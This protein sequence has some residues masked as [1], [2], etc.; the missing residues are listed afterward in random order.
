MSDTL[1]L[2]NVM[3][4]DDDEMSR[5]VLEKFIERADFLRL[6]GSYSNPLDAANSFK[7]E[8]PVD[9]IFLDVEMPE[10][11]GFEFLD[12][13]ENLPQII[14]I[15]G[16]RQ[17]AL[18]AFD[19][20]VVDYLLKPFSTARLFKAVD[21]AYKKFEE[22]NTNEHE[23]ENSFFIK[24]SQA[25]VRVNFEEILW[26]EALENYVVLN[27]FSEKHTIHFTMKAILEKLPA[28]L[29]TRVHRSF[30]VNVTK[31]DLIRDNSIIMKSSKE[32]K[33]IPIAKSY[34]DILMNNLNLVNK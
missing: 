8:E 17:Y 18:D 10:M 5:K 7:N 28:K 33:V 26:V 30:I 27:T 3:I 9:L 29:F 34:K 13:F 32:A 23:F 19:Y 24:S 15:S 6:T 2:M 31:V 21:K 11:T 22:M 16:N 20:D 25:L 12:T 14:I 4:I 1:V